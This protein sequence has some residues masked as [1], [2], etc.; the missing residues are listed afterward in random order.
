MDAT[1]REITPALALALRK[2]LRLSQTELADRL[3]YEQPT[4]SA[5]EL[6][7]RAIPRRAQVSMHALAQLFDVDVEAVAATVTE[8]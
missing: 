6:G 2:A 5:Y 4:I 1:E 8:D 3:G 7:K